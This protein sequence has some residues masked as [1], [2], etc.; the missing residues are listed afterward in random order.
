LKR[1]FSGGWAIDFLVSTCP[2]SPD[3]PPQLCAE[4]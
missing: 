2:S 3:I 4:T 1:R